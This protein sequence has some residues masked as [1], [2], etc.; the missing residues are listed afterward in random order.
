MFRLI[1]TEFCESPIAIDFNAWLAQRGKPCPPVR[2]TIRI[3]ETEWEGERDPDGKRP[4]EVDTMTVYTYG[5]AQFV[6]QTQFADFLQSLCPL[7]G[8]GVRGDV[9]AWYNL[10]SFAKQEA[11]A[12]RV[13]TVN[14][15]RD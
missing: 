2:S 5:T 7:P 11:M 12:Y 6:N 10:I 3:I 8:D 9:N 4:Y 1:E 14:Y 13:K 15:R